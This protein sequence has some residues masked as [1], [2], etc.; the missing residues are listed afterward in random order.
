MTEEHAADLLSGK[1][2]S[3]RCQRCTKIVA[4]QRAQDN[5]QGIWRL[6]THKHFGADWCG[7]HYTVMHEI[8]ETA[9]E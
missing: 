3:Y 5:G 2:L 1:W 7:N 4:T 6:Q 8:A 9:H